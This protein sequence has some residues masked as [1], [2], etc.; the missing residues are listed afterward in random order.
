VLHQLAN[1]NSESS[2]CGG[3][4]NSIAE[5]S[6]LIGAIVRADHPL[7]N[8]GQFLMTEAGQL[9]ETQPKLSPINWVTHWLLSLPVGVCVWSSNF[10][11]PPPAVVRSACDPPLGTLGVSHDFVTCAGSA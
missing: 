4:H 6:Q 1:E 7:T 11:N 2:L 10:R 5:E 9:G 8:L 3:R